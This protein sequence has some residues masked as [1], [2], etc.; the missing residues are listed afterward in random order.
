M[1]KKL[2]TI[3][4][5]GASLISNTGCNS[6]GGFKKYKGIEYKVLKEGDSKKKIHIGDAVEFHLL[7][8]IDEGTPS[9]PKIDTLADS[10]KQQNGKPA[11]PM[12][13][14]EP[15]GSGQFQAVFTKLCVGDSALI[16]IS[17]DTLIKSIPPD[18]ASQ[19]LP[20]WLK[21]GKK[22]KVYLSIVSVKTDAEYK[23]AMKERQEEMKAKQAEMMKEMEEKG[24]LQMPIDDKILT[25]Y[26]AKNN[27]KATKTASGLYYTITKQGSGE[28]AKAG[29][30]VTMMYTGKTLDGK[31]F[32]SNVDPKF[33]HPEPFVFPLGR[34]Q[35]IKGWD[36]GVALLKKGS[37]ANLYI[38]SPLAYGPQ[39]PSADI[40]ANAILVFDVE[41][42]D[43]KNAPADNQSAPPP[44]Q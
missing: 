27:I 33:K 8:I 3:A 15:R 5:L 32:D 16:E 12:S 20:P 23:A 42:V 24:K 14:E 18:Q 21:K 29:Q 26:L 2:F 36:E 44:A 43:I 10:R 30:N 19:P 41:V 22:I 6:N 40:P 31:S 1:I 35:V 7:A 28:T 37:K 4:I 13:V 25:E 38:P 39:S 17:C 34:G 11:G 9:A